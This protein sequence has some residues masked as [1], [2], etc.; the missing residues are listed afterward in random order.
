MP[1]V[2]A[3]QRIDAPP[4]K[5]FAACT[6]LAG[7]PERI[8]GIDSIEVLTEGPVGEGTRFRE[9]RIV[10]GKQATEEMEIAEFDPPRRFVLTCESF[11]TA[12]TT[13]Y[14]FDPDG[15]GTR[16]VLTMHAR[17]VTMVAKLM[18]P[19]AGMMRRTMEKCLRAD[20]EDLRRSCEPQRAG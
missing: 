17:P 11:G 16:L 9:T 7:Q 6:D 14:R 19:M 13:E 8:S 2:T 20:L 1:T 18:T 10:F 12:Y 4:E 5:V 3:E 15:D